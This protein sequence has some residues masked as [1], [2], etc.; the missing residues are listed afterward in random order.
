VPPEEVATGKG[1]QDSHG[2]W[3]G[4]SVSSGWGEEAWLVTS[5]WRLILEHGAGQSPKEEC[6]APNLG[7][8][9]A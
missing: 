7:W 9:Q 3:W 2:E 8:E 1:Y 4:S 6:W 5:V